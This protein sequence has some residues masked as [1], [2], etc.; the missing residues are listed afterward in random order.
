MNYKNDYL[1][2]HLKN[3]VLPSYIEDIINKSPNVILPMTRDD[4]ITLATDNKD[5]FEV[6]YDVKG[7]GR[8]KEANVVKCKNG[9]AINY[10]EDYMR[11]RDP[12]CLLI[13]DKEDTDKKRY[14]DVYNKDFEDLRQE[15][16]K[17]FENEELILMPFKAG[18]PQHG[19]DAIL[20]APSNAGFFAGGLGDLQGFVSFK[21]IKTEFKPKAIIYLAPSFRHSHF[22]GKQRIIHNRLD[23]MH[24]LFS[25]NLYPGPS[26]KKGVYGV[27]LNIGEKEGWVTAHTSSVKVIDPYGKEITIMH[28]GASGG[29]KSEM[30]EN[31]HREMD[32]KLKFAVNTVT[33]EEFYLDLKQT[34]EL[35]PITDDM[36]LCHPDIQQG[37]RRL[38]IKDAEQAW[39]LRLDH[40]TSYGTSPHYEK[41]F[42]H[43]SEPLIFINLQ[44]KV[45]ATCLPW[46]HTIDSDGTPCPNPRVILPRRMIDNVIDKASKID[47]RSFGVRTPPS[48]KANPSYGIMGMLHILPPA[49]AWLWRLVAPRG[50]NNPSITATKGLSSEGVGS[51]WPFATGKLVDHANLLL[52]QFI[53]STNTRNVLIPNQHIG[54]YKTGFMPQWIAREY[55]ARRGG[56]KFTLDE[57]EKARLPIMG[58]CMQSLEIEGQQIRKSFLQPER[59]SQLGTEGYDAGAKILM[60]FFRKELKKFNTE[61]LHPIG[62]QIIELVYNDADLDEYIKL[63]PMKY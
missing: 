57:L 45:G 58:Y 16:F 17:W 2:T 59:Q 26:A 31:I 23:N 60:D 53:N 52:E 7:M 61:K 4:L 38:V 27:L 13:G 6:A 11:R 12:D 9:V 50:H 20:I 48:T 15:T 30:I 34:S 24:E 3:I 54:V 41:I 33:G 55:I 18:G 1:N 49:I 28:E 62:K 22:E 63:I 5:Y 56:A 29:G 36:A 10:F 14:S 8:V 43:P 32:G 25:Y 39:F 19:Y 21:D 37:S 44:G 40:I 47:V 42:I 46:E 51:Y 35:R